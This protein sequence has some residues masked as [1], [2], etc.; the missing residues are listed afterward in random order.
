MP[1]LEG[2]VSVTECILVTSNVSSRVKSGIIVDILLASMVL[3][4]P[5]GPIKRAL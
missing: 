3:P 4:L 2:R 5:G 1:L